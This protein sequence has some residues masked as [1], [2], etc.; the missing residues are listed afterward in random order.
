L[1]TKRLRKF[2]RPRKCEFKRPL[3]FDKKPKDDS[4]G[5]SQGKKQPRS[6]K[7]KNTQGK[8]MNATLSDE[9]N[10]DN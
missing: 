2:F 8:A 1:L 6:K 10:S 3:K 4:D 5:S 9:S 7:E